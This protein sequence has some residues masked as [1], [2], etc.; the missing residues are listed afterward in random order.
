MRLESN[1]SEHKIVPTSDEITSYLLGPDLQHFYLEKKSMDSSMD[2]A[3]I[4]IRSVQWKPG[5]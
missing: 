5:F 1:Y 2:A 4:S 3:T